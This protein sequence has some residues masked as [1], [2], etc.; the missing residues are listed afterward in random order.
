MWQLS[1]STNVQCAKKDIR[2]VKKNIW[3]V[4]KNVKNVKN[5]DWDKTTTETHSAVNLSWKYMLGILYCKMWNFNRFEIQL[6]FQKLFSSFFLLVDIFSVYNSNE[7]LVNK[8]CSCN[9]RLETSYIIT[10]CYHTPSHTQN[11]KVRRPQGK[12]SINAQR[13][14]QEMAT[15]L[16]G[17]QR[18]HFLQLCDTKHAT[19]FL[20]LIT[21]YHYS[22]TTPSTTAL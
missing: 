18:R 22:V 7:I 14:E 13:Y 9:L 20:P 11:H 12:L 19:F 4:K 10:G 3:N 8:P 1:W 6:I 16:T 17:G 15:D 2:N 21:I 5:H